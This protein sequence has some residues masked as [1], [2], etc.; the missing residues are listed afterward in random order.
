[1]TGLHIRYLFVS[2]LTFSALLFGENGLAATE[3]DG[4]EEGDGDAR[5]DHREN[6]VHPRPG[7]QVPC[8]SGSRLSRARDES[9]LPTAVLSRRRRHPA[10]EPHW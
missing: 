10:R 9:H 5:S 2:L 3:G 4:A 7:P 6:E 8:G 1:M